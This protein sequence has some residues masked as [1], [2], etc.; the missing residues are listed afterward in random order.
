MATGHLSPT[1]VLH[2]CKHCGSG[3]YPKTKDRLSFC[4]RECSI[5]NQKAN[6]LSPEEL[7]RRLAERQAAKRVVLKALPCK[8]CSTAFLPKNSRQTLCSY[9][10]RVL[11]SRCSAV[12]YAKRND[13]RD[14]KPRSCAEC[15]KLFV[16]EYGNKKRT[17]CSESCRCKSTKRTARKVGKAR[18]RAATVEYVN[19]TKVFD[20][21]GWRCQLCGCSTPR[22]LRGTLVDRAP[23]LDHII[24]LAAGG[25]HSYR[26]T[27]CACRA[28]NI[29]KGARPLGQMRL[30]A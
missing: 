4:G 13:T 19:P 17:F 10:C 29:A 1:K 7:K 5:A 30:I 2:Q 3:F 24:P 9:E 18:K 8:Q 14:R 12:D 22:R 15:G 27:Q 6:R 23:E 26:N 25:E 28:C 11:S 21:D 16:P 20:R